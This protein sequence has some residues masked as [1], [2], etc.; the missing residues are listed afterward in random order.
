[1][2]NRPTCQ[3]SPVNKRG[4]RYRTK[5]DARPKPKAAMDC[6]EQAPKMCM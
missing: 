1:M 3:Q 6:D 4:V 5:N 2:V